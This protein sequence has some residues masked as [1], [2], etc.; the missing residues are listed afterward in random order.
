MEKQNPP[1]AGRK[2]EGWG[3]DGRCHEE[4]FLGF[5]F[6]NHLPTLT[7]MHGKRGFRSRRRRR[8][9]ETR[10]MRKRKGTTGRSGKKERRKNETERKPLSA[11]DIISP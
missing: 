2:G 1:A 3:D 5:T 10:A 11:F 8:S 7:G 4:D 6:R 9:D